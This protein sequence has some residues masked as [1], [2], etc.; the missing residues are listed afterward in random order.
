M[1]PAGAA[2][3]G[4]GARAARRQV[5][6]SGWA[7]AVGAATRSTAA[8]P[9]AWVVALAGFLARG[10]LV[11]VVLPIVVL[12]TLTG[13]ATVLG[14]IVV[15]VALA[16]PNASLIPLAAV[17]TLAVAAWLVIG[18]LI[19]AV[20]D[21]VLI[22]WFGRRLGD[23][24][25]GGTAGL[26]DDD[27][28]WGRTWRVYAVRLVA[29]VALLPV[30]AMAGTLVV[31]AVYRELT[32]PGDV[33][34]PLVVRVIQSEPGALVAVALTWLVG[35][36]IGALAARRVV[37]LGRGAAG[38]LVSAVGAS[39]RSPLRI[40][41]TA[42]LAT[43]GSVIALVPVIGLLMAA[44]SAT[45][46]LVLGDLGLV[47]LPAIV[48]LVLAFCAALVVAGLASA[49]RSALWTAEDLRQ[50]RRLTPGDDEAPEVGQSGRHAPALPDVDPPDQA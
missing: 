24:D 11:L 38:A 1:T 10:G 7:T 17:S 45:R 30:L 5:S 50:R 4:V 39:I 15:L 3:A 28:L 18:G 19:G 32:A 21:V 8:E 29:H 47:A 25:G 20:A 34:V 26:L 46:T 42:L 49:W 22:R 35:E 48:L 37:L 13:L 36:A 6:G 44:W 43:I 41:A 23:S 27:G 33:T 40:G 16:G 12:P 14:P 9:V 31:S 2:E